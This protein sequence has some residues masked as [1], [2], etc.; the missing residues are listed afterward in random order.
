MMPDFQKV[1]A[2]CNEIVNAHMKRIMMADGLLSQIKSYREF[3]GDSM[4]VRPEGHRHE[5]QSSYDLVQSEVKISRAEM[6]QK[7]LAAYLER[8][9]P[10]AMDMQRQQV[11][12][13]FKK[14]EEVTNATGNVLD[15]K[16]QPP[17]PELLLAALDKVW[18]DFDDNGNPRLP[19]MFSG[20]EAAPKM[21]D[22]LNKLQTEEPYKKKHDDLIEKK[23]K[24]WNDRES[25]R[26]LVD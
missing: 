4:S 1:K 3:E 21:R 15:A 18:I 26:K 19:T 10:A 2:R 23:R 11:Q 7:G 8:V 24:E 22:A 6:I 12:K 5:K 16:G 14:I 20:T 25:H 9:T 13:I 17:T